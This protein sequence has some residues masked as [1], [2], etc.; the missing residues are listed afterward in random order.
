MLLKI[1]I[2]H[3][4]IKHTWNQ[5]YILILYSYIRTRSTFSLFS[6][7]YTYTTLIPGYRANYRQ[8]DAYRFYY[9]QTVRYSCCCCCCCYEQSYIPDRETVNKYNRARALLLVN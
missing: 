9:Y 2:N 4:S 1:T 6:K 3:G 8:Y 5:R 7:T